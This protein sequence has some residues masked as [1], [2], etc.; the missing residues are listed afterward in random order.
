MR[1]SDIKLTMNVY[2]DLKLLEVHGAL[3]ALPILPL[4]AERTAIADAAKATDPTGTSLSQFAR[5][6]AGNPCKPVQTGSISDNGVSLG[7]GD[8]TG[9]AAA[10]RGCLDSPFTTA[11]ALFEVVFI[12]VVR[13]HGSSHPVDHRDVDPRLAVGGCCS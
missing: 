9:R 11:S 6:F 2:T 5:Q 10:V 8:A 3:D 7:T 1:H 4:D 12:L 13:K